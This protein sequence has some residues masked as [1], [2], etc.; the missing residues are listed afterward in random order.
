MDVYV[1]DIC[2][3]HRLTLVGDPDNGIAPGTRFEDI[4]EDWVCSI[5]GVAKDQ[6]SRNKV[7]LKNEESAFPF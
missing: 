1:C 7:F 6:F 2:E 5:C 4:P 3:L